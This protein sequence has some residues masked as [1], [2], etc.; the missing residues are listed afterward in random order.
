MTTTLAALQN[1]ARYMAA[2]RGR[3]VL[4]WFSAG[5]PIDV[6]GD[7]PED[8]EASREYSS[9]LATAFRPLESELVG[10]GFRQAPLPRLPGES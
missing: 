6:M 9:L 10:L 1:I 5:F 3:K 4:L 8:M 7:Q 2:R